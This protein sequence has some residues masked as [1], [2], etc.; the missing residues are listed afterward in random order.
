MRYEST[1]VTLELVAVRTGLLMEAFTLTVAE[2]VTKD[3]K[4]PW[5]KKPEDEE[6][7]LHEVM[8]DIEVVVVDPRLAEAPPPAGDDSEHAPGAEP[9]AAA[10]GS[11][12]GGDQA[13]KL[14]TSCGG[15]LV[16]GA[17]FCHLCGERVA[18]PVVV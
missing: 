11:G 2:G 9:V 16:D 1:H 13:A 3:G 6:F 17:R 12:D 10:G 5:T 14:C 7:P 4:P 8:A 18:A 15:K